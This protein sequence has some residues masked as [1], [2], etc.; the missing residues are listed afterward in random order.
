MR[1]IFAAMLISAAVAGCASVGEDNG[2]WTGNGAEPFDGAVTECQARE[3]Q[4]H[5]PEFEACM[6][7]K[8]WTRP[9]R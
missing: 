2:G 9:Q 4:S 6:A 1:R 7:T 8:G 3:Q 5:G